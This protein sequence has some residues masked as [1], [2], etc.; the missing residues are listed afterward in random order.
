MGRNRHRKNKSRVM[1]EDVQPMKQGD[2]LA[3]GSKPVNGDVSL[4]DPL[5]EKSA[6][7]VLKK[8]KEA[9]TTSAEAP[10]TITATPKASDMK[11]KNRGS[12]GLSAKRFFEHGEAQEKNKNENSSE[13]GDAG[14]GISAKEQPNVV[15]KKARKRKAHSESSDARSVKQPSMD[16]SKNLFDEMI[17]EKTLDR[18]NDKAKNE[19]KVG[20]KDKQ[21][22]KKGQKRKIQ[23]KENG[24]EELKVEIRS[25]EKGMAPT[26]EI[27]RRVVHKKM[28]VSGKV[29]EYDSEHEEGESDDT[30]GKK[31]DSIVI[32]NA[33][34]IIIKGG[35]EEEEEEED[36]DEEEEEEDEEEEEEDEEEEDEEETEDDEEVPVLIGT[37]VGDATTHKAKKS[38]TKKRVPQKPDREINVEDYRV[39]IMPAAKQKG[40]LPTISFAN[41]LPFSKKPNS[42][43]NANEAW[44]WVIS[45]CSVQTFFQ[46]IFQKKVLMV[47]RKNP[48]YYGDFYNTKKF[49]EILQQHHVEYGT[50]V[51][52]AVYVEGERFTPN[53]IGKV[54]PEDIRAHLQAGH[55]VQLVNPQTFCDSVWHVCEVLQELFGSFV[56]ANTYLTPAGTAG[57]APHWDEIDAFLMQLEG[58]KHW[59]VFAPLCDADTL[60]RESSGNFSDEDMKGRTPVFDDW[61]EQGDLIYIPRGFIHQGYADDSIHSL[62]L[63][64]SV[65]RRAAFVDLLEKMIPEVVTAVG[66]Q[67]I[68]LRSSLPPG[69]LDMMG[70][71][72]LDYYLED[73]ATDKLTS[74]LDVHMKTVKDHAASAYEAAIDMMA[75][76]FMKTALPPLLTDEERSLSAYGCKDFNLFSKEL[77]FKPDTKIRLIRKHAQR[78][79]FETERKSFIVHRMANSR[80]YEGRPEVLFSLDVKLSTGFATLMN[81]YPE[82]ISVSELQCPKVRDKNRLAKLL[83]RN[84]L[85]MA[86]F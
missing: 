74:V 50:N 67:V 53:G 55:S 47:S 33:E 60:P 78:L 86:K 73:K 31:D 61:V 14:H 21:K 16:D 17:L 42:L 68:S 15:S 38:P 71:L 44:N 24:K 80:V 56:G 22:N 79:I 81:A 2:T 12:D 49:V 5:Q 10:P 64:I 59:K 26:T 63:T 40:P 39:I 84:G 18:R 43:S 82:W 30:S 65:C 83:Y 66:D 29:V 4:R 77:E 62:H 76:E 54:Y 45:P 52:A 46:E 37:N 32:E 13:H 35:L 9:V 57:F 85:L 51:N 34:G 41:E 3:R 1:P 11:K 48:S 58:R 72:P 8:P 36:E 28:V 25:E 23:P 6:F 75:R 27:R 70:V 69:Y 7:E 19:N 20:K